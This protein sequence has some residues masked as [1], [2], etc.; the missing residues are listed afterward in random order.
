VNEVYERDMDLTPEFKEM[1][2]STHKAL[3]GAERRLFMARAVK[4]LGQ[5][6]QYKAEKELGWNRGTIRKGLRELEAGQVC[7]DRRKGYTGR[8]PVEAE[9]PNLIE[10]IKDIVDSQSQVD[11]RFETTRLYRR[12]STAEVIRQLVAQKGYDK[13]ALPC[14]ETIRTR[15]DSLGYRPARVQKSK[16]KKNSRDR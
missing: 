5:G 9:L 8:K 12:I 3:R 10:D 11:P 4:T 14:E 16:P 15:L 2:I 1:L 13:D 7:E 6:G